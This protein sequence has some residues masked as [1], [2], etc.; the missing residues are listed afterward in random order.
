MARK[1]LYLIL[2]LTGNLHASIDLN[3]LQA[4]FDSGDVKRAYDYAAAEVMNYEGDPGFDYYYGIAAI[5]TG[6]ASEGVFA[7]ERVLIA[8]PDNH[9]AR[10]ELA[11]GY[12]ILEEYARAR[13][14]FETVLGVEPPPDVE[15]KIYGYLDAIRLQEGRYTT[16]QNAYIEFG[17]GTDSNV[18]SGPDI[19]SYNIGTLT[20]PLDKASQEQDDTFS[21]ITLNY[22]INT[23]VTIGTS[24][25]ATANGNAH[26]NSD[27][28]EFDTSTVTVNSGFQF[29]RAQDAYSIDIT[30]Q[31]FNLDGEDYRFLIGLS[32]NWRRHLSQQATLQTFLQLAQQE[33]DG[34]ETRDV[35]T[36]SLGVSYSKRFNAIFSPVFFS[37]LNLAQDS[38]KLDTDTAK[39]NSERDYYGVR[40]GTI[41]GTS[42]KTSTKL[43]INYQSSEYGLADSITGLIREDDYLNA[44]IDFTYLVNRNW[45]MYARASITENDSNNSLYEYDRTIL[46]LNIRYAMK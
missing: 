30:A 41:L 46:S 38:P 32:T 12:F 29:L 15:E 7:L 36:I 45:S 9:A 35:D 16:T 19:T 13:E 42:A 28:G 43:S 3:R 40:I 8:Q 21:E 37:S 17:Y 24:F 22:G 14:E 5:D 25:Y 2:F 33:F 44:A 39:Q 31:Q 23:P 27:H 34:Q 26:L 11:R 6:H 20:V 4:L 10:L 1:T 18:N